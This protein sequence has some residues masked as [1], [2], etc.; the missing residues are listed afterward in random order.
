[1]Q[2]CHLMGRS[3]AGPWAR[4]LDVDRTLRLP[5]VLDNRG[6]ARRAAGGIREVTERIRAQRVGMTQSTLGT[7]GSLG[8]LSATASL[9]DKLTSS[10]YALGEASFKSSS[11]PVLLVPCLYIWKRILCRNMGR[12]S[13]LQ[14]LSVCC[15]RRRRG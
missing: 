5:V 12:R 14:S 1:M 9:A 8:S 6:Q 7:L 3:R 10:Q 2:H 15:C 11:H 4:L 13:T